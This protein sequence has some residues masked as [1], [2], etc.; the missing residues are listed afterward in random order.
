MRWPPRRLPRVLLESLVGQQPPQRTKDH[1]PGGRGSRPGWAWG[2][3]APGRQMD[4]LGAQARGGDETAEGRGQGEDTAGAA[5][6]LGTD[7]G[8][9]KEAGGMGQEVSRAR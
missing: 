2:G 6:R 5:P 1:P 8:P 9:E 4:A 3:C 7:R